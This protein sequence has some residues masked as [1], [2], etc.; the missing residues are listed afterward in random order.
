MTGFDTTK[1]QVII[2]LSIHTKQITCISGHSTLPSLYRR[3][4]YA[5]VLVRAGGHSDCIGSHIVFNIKVP[6]SRSQLLVQYPINSFGHDSIYRVVATYSSPPYC[7]LCN[8]SKFLLILLF[9]FSFISLYRTRLR[10]GRSRTPDL[11]KT[12]SDIN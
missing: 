1:R 7:S 4:R 2:K 12:D 5:V 9:H 8:S 11:Y 3:S 10:D 6:Q